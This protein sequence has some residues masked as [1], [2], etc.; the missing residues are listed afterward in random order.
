[1][2]I[3]GKGGG[4]KSFIAAT[5]ARSLARAR[6]P[7][8]ALDIDTMPG[9]ALSLG[10]DAGPEGLPGDL[11][12][13]RPG[14][15]WVM[16]TAVPAT[17]LVSR[18]SVGAPDG[19][20]LLT[21]G[22]LPGHLKPSSSAVFRHVARTFDEPGWSIV[23]DLPGGVRQPSFGWTEFAD[24][25]VLV[26]EP[27]AKSQ[28]AAQRVARIVAGS[29]SRV[30]VVVSKWRPGDD[31]GAIAASLGLPLVGV[32]PYDDRVRAAESAGKAPLDAVP[33]AA[34]V[35]AVQELLASLEA[36]R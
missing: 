8:L 24:I 10:A 27:T 4:G 9:L 3:A 34:A 14:V 35:R 11:A 21:L 13:E 36:V 31:A 20:R 6:G 18:Y 12:E 25:A 22:K 5:L 32:V 23:A 16:R 28:L 17:E 30:V 29:R 7:V 26:V 19:V 1:V 33:D 15:G 2:A